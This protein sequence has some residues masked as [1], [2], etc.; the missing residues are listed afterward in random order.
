MQKNKATGLLPPACPGQDVI[1]TPS[2]LPLFPCY[3]WDGTAAPVPRTESAAGIVCRTA[4]ELITEHIALQDLWVWPA[5]GGC[6]FLHP[7]YLEDTQF[8][9]SFLCVTLKPC[10]TAVNVVL[11]THGLRQ[12]E[13]SQ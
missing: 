13:K 1:S 11:A 12:T 9:G 3:L 7:G 10:R 4:S 8:T 5:E 2:E 6:D